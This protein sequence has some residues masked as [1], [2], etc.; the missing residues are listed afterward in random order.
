MDNSDNINDLP[1]DSTQPTHN[2]L[3]IVNNLFKE[4]DGKYMKLFKEMKSIIIIGVLFIIF[5]LPQVDGL[6]KT[7]VP[8]SENSPYIL[9]L[10]KTIVFVGIY[11]FLNYFYLARK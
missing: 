7:F 6:V 3:Q 9:V 4:K 1:V 10:S 2:E 5:S 11:Y 8:S